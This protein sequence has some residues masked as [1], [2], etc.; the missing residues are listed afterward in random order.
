MSKPL[1]VIRVPLVSEASSSMPLAAL[2]AVVLDTETTGLDARSAR[3]IQIGAVLIQGAKI[4][5][6]GR[7]DRLIDPGIPIPPA[8]TLVHGITDQMVKGAPAFAAVFEE[9]DRYLGNAI[10]TGASS[11]TIRMCL[12][13]RVTVDFPNVAA[14]A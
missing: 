11:S 9:L 5:P 14:G 3:I 6:D 13:S 4:L 10:A 1:Q 2:D 12:L 7:L 8:T